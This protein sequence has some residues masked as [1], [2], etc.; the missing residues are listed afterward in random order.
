MSQ[1][2]QQIIAI[3]VFSNISRSKGNEATKCGQ[4]VKYKKRNIVLK[5]YAEKEAGETNSRSI[6]FFNKAF[7][8]AKESGQ[9]LI[10]NIFQ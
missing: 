1:T 2:E 6:L 9:H 4:L 7:H 8:K 3:H 10:F 5:K